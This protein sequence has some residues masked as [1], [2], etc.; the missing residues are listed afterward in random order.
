M[1]VVM[2]ASVLVKLV[3]EEPG[4]TAARALFVS[5]PTLVAPDLA[6]IEV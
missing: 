3:A 2:D 1:T 6:L 4:S 5:E